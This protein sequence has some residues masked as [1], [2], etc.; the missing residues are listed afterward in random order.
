MT[1]DPSRPATP[2]PGPA[3]RESASFSPQP[4]VPSAPALQIGKRKSSGA[5]LN[6]ILVVA[7]VV[8]VGGVA[9]AIGRSTA[10]VAAASARGNGLFGNGN[11]PRGSFAPDASGARGD[12]FLG[13]LRGGGGFSL[14]GTVQSVTGDTLTITTADG[15]TL[16][17]TLGA[18]TTYSTRAPATAAEVKPGS[19][20]EVQ[21]QLGNG[22][23]FRPNASGAPSGPV[24][25]AG[26]VTIVP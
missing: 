13:G 15:R 5:W 17:F 20:V 8:A 1:F 23:A 11:F 4:V 7:A 19:K 26:N 18:G 3:P 21:L 24:G 22:N 6:I 16:E 2:E 10:P 12:G 25:T 9:F 14:S